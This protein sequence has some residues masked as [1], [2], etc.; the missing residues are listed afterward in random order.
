LIDK[1]DKEAREREVCVF[2]RVQ[3][4]KE[5]KANDERARGEMGVLS[6]V[7]LDDCNQR[8]KTKSRAV[9][10]DMSVWH[11]WVNREQQREMTVASTRS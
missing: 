7:Y 4:S 2:D 11:V 9:V 10:L 5:R 3:Q 8:V 1:L 6:E